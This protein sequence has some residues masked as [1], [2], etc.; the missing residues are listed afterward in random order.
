MPRAKLTDRTVANLQPPAAGRVEIF[1]LALPGFGV[2]VTAAGIRTFFLFYRQHGRQ[3]RLS[4]GRYNPPVVT[5]A[6][7]RAAAQKALRAVELGQDPAD[8][9]AARRAG[10][11]VTLADLIGQKYAEGDRQY[12]YLKFC[13]EKLFTRPAESITR[14]EWRDLI[15]ATARRAPVGA[16]RLRSYLNAAYGR[17][18]KREILAINPVDGLPDVTKGSEEHTS[19]LQSLMRIS[20]AVFCLK[21]KNKTHE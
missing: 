8:E 5:L 15:D 4:L 14:R 1:D 21:K 10:G 18:V 9:Q 12:K 17:A 16:N 19:E 20:Y 7:A 3:R 11:G 6:S 13:C 2:R